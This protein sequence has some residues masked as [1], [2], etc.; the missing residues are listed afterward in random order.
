M[1]IENMT[2]RIMI[3]FTPTEYR[4][5]KVGADYFNKKPCAYMRKIIEEYN[6]QHLR[7]IKR[8]CNKAIRPKN[9]LK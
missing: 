6:D 1:A 7:A 4:K 5:I 9:K 3:R 2:K 8:K